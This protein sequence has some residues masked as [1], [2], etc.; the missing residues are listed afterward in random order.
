LQP[1]RAHN[2]PV[3]ASAET[4]DIEIV[5]NGMMC[6]GC[7]KRI[8]EELGKME[9]V[10]AIKADLE[11]GLVTVSVRSDDPST[12]AAMMGTLV[13]DINSMGFEAQPNSSTDSS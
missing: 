4:V 7:T 10:S 6:E 2:F 1:H 5:V 8:E 13:Q 3:L 12:A 9:G 11:S